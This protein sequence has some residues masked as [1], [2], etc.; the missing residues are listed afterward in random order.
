MFIDAFLYQRH[1]IGCP[2]Y[3]LHQPVTDCYGCLEPKF[4]SGFFRAAEPFSGIVPRSLGQELYA[5]TVCRHFIDH[6]CQVDYARLPAAGNVVN[7]PGGSHEGA[8]DK[9]S[10]D[11]V[12]INKI[13]GGDTFVLDRKGHALEGLINKGRVHITPD[14]R[15]GPPPLPRPQYF[16]RAIYVLEPRP[17]RRKAVL[18]V[19]IYRIEFTDNL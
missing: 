2:F 18:P 11:I 14:R 12:H 6:S 13:P 5:G 10:A 15:R 3:S 9:P 4:P 19:K 1:V 17:D 7:I 16:S 8:G